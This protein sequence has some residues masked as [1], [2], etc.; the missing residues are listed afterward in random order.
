MAQNDVQEIA[1]NSLPFWSRFTL[2][3][4]LRYDGVNT[5][6][7]VISTGRQIPVFDYRKGEQNVTALEGA[8]ATA[9]DTILVQANQTRGGG[10]Y[11]IHGI[12]YTKDG[13]AYVAT[14]ASNKNKT[15]HNKFPPSSLQPGNGTAGPL[16]MTVEDWRAM[17]SLMSHVYLDVV[18]TQINIDGTRRILEMG[19]APFYPGVGGAAGGNVDT[20]NGGTFVA[21][22]LHIPEG[23][24]WNP[25]GTVDS[26]F[27]II[28]EATYD[29]VLPT[30]TAPDG[31][32]PNGQP[33]PNANPTPIGR[34][35][36]QGWVT[37][38]HGAEESPTSN[39]S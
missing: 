12:S 14:S 19:P 32:A 24:I 38:L 17:D 2:S 29:L 20:S 33:I 8:T 25:A 16:V 15:I 28:L 1:L 5:F 23:I 30:W 27:Q 7:T 18:R 10:L 31:L 13:W 36:T 9:R 26:N 35:W 3:A 4:D 34:Y 37:N 6:Q 21:N 11:R 22:Y 39:V